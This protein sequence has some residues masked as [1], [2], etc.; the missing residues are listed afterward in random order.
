MDK[1]AEFVKDVLREGLQKEISADFWDNPEFEDW[2]IGNDDWKDN[3]WP[4]HKP[5]QKTRSGR[6]VRTPARFRKW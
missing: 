3:N 4:G 2:I 5:N 6:N 1:Q